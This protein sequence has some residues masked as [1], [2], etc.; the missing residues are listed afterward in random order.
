[1]PLKIECH[2]KLNVRLITKVTRGAAKT[3]CSAVMRPRGPVAGPG[4]LWQAPG[5][6]GRPWGPVLGPLGKALH[7][8]HCKLYHAL[9]VD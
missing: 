5:P 1:M 3:A 9:V 6:W 4:A 8:E 7:L 2:L